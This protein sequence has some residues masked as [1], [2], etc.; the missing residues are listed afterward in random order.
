VQYLVP[1]QQFEMLLV[2]PHLTALPVHQ[3]P[4]LTVHQKAILVDIVVACIDDN[5]HV[6][7][8]ISS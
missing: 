2:Q 5:V 3:V 6:D 1:L 7:K 8:V 4:I